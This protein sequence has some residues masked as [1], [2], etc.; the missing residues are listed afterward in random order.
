MSDNIAFARMRDL[1]EVVGS[2]NRRVET[3]EADVE[4]GTSVRMTGLLGNGVDRDFSISHGLG[5]RFV[6]VE[7]FINSGDYLNIEADVKRITPN[8][9]AV[10]FRD[11]PSPN[12]FGFVLVGPSA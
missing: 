7:L 6:S 8:A 2:I 1:A 12:Q 5:T 4:P 9:V 3:L 11:I 10:S